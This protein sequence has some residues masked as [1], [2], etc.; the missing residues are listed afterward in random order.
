MTGK[1]RTTVSLEKGI[2]DK[3]RTMMADE[4]FGDFS[5]FLEQVI[6]ERWATRQ[7]PEPPPAAAPLNSGSPARKG[8]GSKKRSR[9]PASN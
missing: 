2:L 9:E 5:G 4:D 7:K 3:A 8:S 6:R 1:K